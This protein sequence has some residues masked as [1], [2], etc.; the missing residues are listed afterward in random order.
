MKRDLEG[1]SRV[2]FIELIWIVQDPGKHRQFFDA[3][4]C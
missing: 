4:K 2:K 1:T 3:A